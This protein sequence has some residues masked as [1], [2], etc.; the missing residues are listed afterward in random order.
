MRK[1]DLYEVEARKNDLIATLTKNH[2]KDFREIKNFYNDIT[3]NNLALI[4]TLKV[5]ATVWL[6]WFTASQGDTCLILG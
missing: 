6:M 4:Q 1:S 5:G 2:E 3:Q